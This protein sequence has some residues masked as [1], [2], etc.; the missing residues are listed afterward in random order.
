[1]NKISSLLVLFFVCTNLFATVIGIK[2]DSLKINRDSTLNQKGIS[3]ALNYQRTFYSG[4]GSAFIGSRIKYLLVNYP[5][6]NIAFGIGYHQSSNDFYVISEL[7]EYN[8]QVTTLKGSR[9]LNL[10]SAG[11]SFR[12]IFKGSKL[13][14]YVESGFS[15]EKQLSG[16]YEGESLNNLHSNSWYDYA[17]DSSIYYSYSQDEYYNIKYHDIFSTCLRYGLL[18]ETKNKMQWFSDVGIIYYMGEYKFRKSKTNTLISGTPP[19][20]GLYSTYDFWDRKMVFSLFMLNL[21]FGV[22]F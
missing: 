19:P 18:A 5:F 12:Y 9:K 6:V 14:S 17:G 11:I 3:L 22:Q 10:L 8:N 4:R 1:M 15:I 21:S 7:D 13:S 2:P 16:V 20:N